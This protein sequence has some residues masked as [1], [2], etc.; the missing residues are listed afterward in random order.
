MDKSCQGFD[1]LDEELDNMVASTGA[2]NAVE[3]MKEMQTSA[4]CG[5]TAPQAFGKARAMFK[6]G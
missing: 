6:N 5:S 4:L 2:C 1:L 3:V